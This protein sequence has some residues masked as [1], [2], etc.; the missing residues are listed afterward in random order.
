MD[1]PEF[2]KFIKK[3][4]NETNRDACDSMRKGVANLID[5]VKKRHMDK[6]A[7]CDPDS[8]HGMAS[9]VMNSIVMSC[10]DMVKENLV[11]V[12]VF[13]ATDEAEKEFYQ[14]MTEGMHNDSSS[15]Q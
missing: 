5:E 9:A 8:Q 7:K 2:D 1:I 12:N 4:V 15:P 11:N 13:V 10:L 14:T 6:M 3:V